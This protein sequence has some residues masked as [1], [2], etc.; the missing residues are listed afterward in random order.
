MLIST[1]SKALHICFYMLAKLSSDKR[2]EG[3]HDCKRYI[4]KYQQLHYQYQLSC[5]INIAFWW[6]VPADTRPRQQLEL[7]LICVVANAI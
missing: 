7:M 1:L 5:S 2:S 4:E 6:D 3:I